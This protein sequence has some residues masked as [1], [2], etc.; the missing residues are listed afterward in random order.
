RLQLCYPS[1]RIRF[2]NT[3]KNME[4]ILGKTHWAIA[5]G[6]IPSESTGSDPEMTSH[7]TACILNTSDKDAKIEITIFFSDKDPFGPYKVTVPAKRV[8]HLRFN[9][10]KNP[11]EIPRNTDY[12][13][14]IVSDVPVVVQHTR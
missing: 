1:H 8:L 9:E 2:F 4:Y 5:E 14:T 7:E 10:L 12:A 13:S 11:A 3:T 6:Y